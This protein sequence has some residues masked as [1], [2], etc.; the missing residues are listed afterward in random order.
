MYYGDCVRRSPLSSSG[1]TLPLQIT[2]TLHQFQLVPP[3]GDTTNTTLHGVPAVIYNGGRSIE[4]YT[5]FQVVDIVA[6]TPKLANDAVK[7][8][9]PFNRTITKDF[10][11]LP[12]PLLPAAD[13]DGAD[14]LNGG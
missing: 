10:P 5:D 6:S 13:S 12:A 7:A 1:C 11:G 14:R 4:L 8:L 9:T 3:L 2:T